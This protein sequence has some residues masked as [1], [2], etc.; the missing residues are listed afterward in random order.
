MTVVTEEDRTHSGNNPITGDRGT[1]TFP[2]TIPA[3]EIYSN[4]TLDIP[5]QR[6]GGAR[7]S[8]QPQPGAT[9]N[10]QV[11]INW[12]FDGGVNPTAGN[13]FVEYHVKA[14]SAPSGP[15]APIVLKDD[16]Q[17]FRGSSFVMGDGGTFTVNF[18]IPA[19]RSYGWCQL[20]IVSSVRGGARI[21]AQ[22]APGTTGRN[23]S[24]SINWWYD[25]TV[26]YRAGRGSVKFRVRV[27]A[28]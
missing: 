10:Q 18:D 4:A 27:F 12:W 22:P 20:D 6:R 11:E 24:V 2:I 7:I 9:G 5:G 17:S 13:G 15:G 23:K 14:F 25:G 16:T 1:D 19:G 8:A 3:G 26:N 21:S 28:S